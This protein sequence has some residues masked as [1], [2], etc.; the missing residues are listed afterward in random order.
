[1]MPLVGCYPG[2]LTLGTRRLGVG[3]RPKAPEA[4]LADSELEVLMRV[5]VMHPWA[6]GRGRF[7][8][9]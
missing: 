8:A 2:I 6:G 7:V 5:P 9:F 4:R 1:M 3:Q